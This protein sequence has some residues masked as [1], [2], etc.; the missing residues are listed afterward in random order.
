M[1]SLTIRIPEPVR[2]RLRAEA[3]EQRTT[4]TALLLGPWLRPKSREGDK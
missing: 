2:A 1:P 3:Y 4:V